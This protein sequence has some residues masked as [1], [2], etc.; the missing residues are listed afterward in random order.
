[1]KY[2]PAL[3]LGIL[4]ALSS[5]S[6]FALVAQAGYMA[7]LLQNISQMNHDNSLYLFLGVHDAVLLLL[8]S[9]VALSCYRLVFGRHPFD[10]MAAALMQMPLGMVVLWTDGVSLNVFSYYGLARTLTTLAATFGV[11]VIY[12]LMQR[13]SRTIAIAN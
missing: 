10:L 7:E 12:G 13:R 3:G 4:L 9:A 8:L 6:C 1:M 2:L 5:F 11:L